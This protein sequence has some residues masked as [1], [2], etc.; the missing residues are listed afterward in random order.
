MSN[1]WLRKIQDSRNL[2][3]QL[4][5]VIAICFIGIW[6][7]QNR[8]LV[9]EVISTIGPYKIAVLIIFLSLVLFVSSLSLVCTVRGVGYDISLLDAYNFLN[10]SQIAS[11]IPGKI[12]GFASL[13]SMLVSK[14]IR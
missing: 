3:S 1:N 9:I 13:V 6:I 4:I 12:W 10:V 11:M 2:A 14:R 5:S 8:D 7:W